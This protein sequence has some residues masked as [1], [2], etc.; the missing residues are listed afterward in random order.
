[1]RSDDAQTIAAVLLALNPWLAILLL[2]R[3]IC[4]LMR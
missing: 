3:V 2:I 4:E 1:M